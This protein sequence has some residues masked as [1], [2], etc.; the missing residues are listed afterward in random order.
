VPGAARRIDR[1]VLTVSAD[2]GIARGRFLVED[3]FRIA[4]FPGE[5]ERRVLAIRRLDL[6]VVDPERSSAALAPVI[7]EAVRAAAGHAVRFDDPAAPAADAVYFPDVLVATAAFVERLAAP[8]SPTEWFWEAVLEGRIPR[9]D[10]AAGIR[11]ALD[12]LLALPGGPVR[13]AML[14]DLLRTRGTLDRLLACLQAADAATM[15]A[16]F[17][18][19]AAPGRHEPASTGA[20]RDA[21]AGGSASPEQQSELPPCI[22]PA[23]R[24]W[25]DVLQLWTARWG[26]SDPRSRW[27]AV[28]ALVSAQPSI[29]GHREVSALAERVLRVA[30]QRRRAGS[31]RPAPGARRA[32]P[33]HA[34]TATRVSP[35]SLAESAA[36]SGL[37]AQPTGDPSRGPAVG[38]GDSATVQ[39]PEPMKASW[40][41][42]L[43]P[44]GAAGLLFVLPLLSRLGIAELLAVDSVLV[45]LEFPQRLLLFIA[46]RIRVTE[47]D[48]VRAPLAPAGPGPPPVDWDRAL[49]SWFTR[50]RRAA[51]RRA[52][53]GLYAL[54]ARPGQIASTRTHIDIVLPLR[55]LDIRVRRA[56]LDADPGWVPWLGKMVTFHYEVEP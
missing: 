50:V 8:S 12:R 51:Y 33:Q 23:L 9:S 42:D 30:E 24:A 10:V 46:D 41:W 48:A 21:Q 53:M 14:A 39:V 15:L 4:S 31:P 16:A 28:A 40:D 49:A 47:D 13:V 27:L 6:G 36:P 25:H 32:T 29:L 3:A 2:D 18:L 5:S 44:T 54:V 20:V 1:L 43:R 35:P 17:G 19:D 22:V 56:G 38:P 55:D 37:R 34:A 26:E 11:I 45:E 52:R 7:E